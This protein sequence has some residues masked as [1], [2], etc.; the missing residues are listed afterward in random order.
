MRPGLIPGTEASVTI[1][2]TEEMF[3]RFEELGL[4]HPIYSTWFMVKHMELAS[5]KVVLPYLEPGE[6]AVGY[7]VHVTHRSPTSA[8]ATVTAR[9]RLVAIDG[10]QIVCAVSAHNG[11]ATIGDGTTIQVLVPADTLRARLAGIGA[12]GP[13]R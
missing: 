2:V 10:N 13:A 11:Q 6:E 7:S 4:V 12:T 5:R 9:A 1:T 8:G 3:A